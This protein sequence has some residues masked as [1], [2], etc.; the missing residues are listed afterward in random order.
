MRAIAPIAIASCVAAGVGE[1]FWPEDALFNVEPFAGDLSQI[2][3]VFLLLGPI[4]GVVAVGLMQS[5]RQTQKFT[6]RRGLGAASSLSIAVIL[7]SIGG[8][9]VPEALGL[10]GKTIDGLLDQTYTPIYILFI[11]AMKLALTAVCLGFGLF[12]GI[13]LRLS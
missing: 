13:F 11:F 5:V 7:T 1:L 2:L 12:G 8:A 4:F 3:P 6:T 9:F 10:G